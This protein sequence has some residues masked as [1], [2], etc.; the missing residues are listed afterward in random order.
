ME[1]SMI[2]YDMRTVC[3]CSILNLLILLFFLIVPSF[4]IAEGVN[5]VTQSGKNVFLYK[6]YYA[7]IV[8]VSSY[9]KWQD[10]PNAARDAKDISI[11]LRKMGF[12][13]TLLTDPTSRELKKAL[14]DMVQKHGQD[15]DR[16]ILFY[17]SGH[18]ETQTLDDGTKRGWIIPR[19]CPLPADAPARFAH[20][21]VS[22]DDIA[23]YSAQILSRH[24]LM[25]FDASFSSTGLS[26]ETPV[27]E[28]MSDRSALPV[29]QYIIAGK[30]G[31]SVSDN[32]VFTRF[33]MNG[34][35]GYA[36]LVYDS[37]ITGSELGV[38]LGNTVV[39]N[40]GG[41]RHPGYGTFKDPAVT[42]GD[43]IFHP[44]KTTPGKG[45]I[46]VVA[47][48]ADAQIR[49]LNIRPR[50]FQGIELMP[51]K[52]HMEFAAPG[53]HNKRTWITL[54]AGEDRTIEISL[55][56]IGDS[57]INTLGMKF[58][59][60]RSGSFMM[61][62]PDEEHDGFHDEDQHRA[63]LKRNYFMQ[64]TEVTAGQFRHFVDATGYM[65]EGETTGCWVSSGSGG[66]KKQ[67]G[68]TWRNPGSWETALYKQTDRH[69]VTCV[70]WNDAQ[71]FIT[72]LT[73][74]EGMAYG[75]PT[76]AEWEYA[77]RAGT[78]TPFSSGKCLSTDQA[79]YGSVD[80]LF[81]DCKDEYRDNR[82]RSIPAGTLA[83]NPWGL[84]DMHGN[85]SEW[86][87]DWYGNYPSRH[88]SDPKGPSSGSTRVLRGGHWLSTAYGS[89]SAK[90][91]SFKPDFAS[92]V[93]GFR[94]VIRP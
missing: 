82:R 45:R 15:K 50:F 57:F 13:I 58:I 38:F 41:R 21:A 94:L 1:F 68:S 25:I 36:D 72:W 63:T 75:L 5:I 81:S 65:T 48:P 77:C 90:R 7:L 87:A 89:R 44:V 29:R 84:F 8:G 70:S 35:K 34:L 91:S 92:D 22:T 23:S 83:A 73:K 37:F 49:V 33:L 3:R 42:G 12:R 2:H 66:W 39:K 93:A 10:L 59:V 14:E 88:V 85:V 51:G 43:F 19:D 27:L 56:K 55:K 26:F 62:S 40:T 76:E 79:N 78:G 24:L 11:L 31:E 4:S 47:E 17:F 61:G 80:P 69:P 52:Y 6:D 18:G 32:G 86:C 60:I 30:E 74:K 16:G 67:K 71:A 53:F 9:E 46:F 28:A 20:L 64:T 54:E